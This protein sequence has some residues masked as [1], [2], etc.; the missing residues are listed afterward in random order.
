MEP[1]LDSSRH[2]RCARKSRVL[3]VVF[4]LLMLAAL[5]TAGSATAQEC[6]DCHDVK[7]TPHSA[8]ENMKCADCHK[9]R[10]EIPHPANASL[11]RCDSC[12]EEQAGQFRIGMH[13]R[14]RAAGNAAAPD[15]AVC[16]GSAHDVE[17]PGTTPFRRKTVDLCGSCHTKEATQYKRS[18]HGVAL[19]HGNR[20]VPYCVTCHGEHDNE[21]PSN[22]GA[23]GTIRETCARCHGNVA[24]MSRFGMPTDRIVSYDQ[25]YHG[26][27]LQAGSQRVANCASC[28][29]IH[30]ILPSSDPRSSTNVKNL[31]HTCGKCHPGAGTR[32]AIGPIHVIEGHGQAPIAD[33]IRKI[34]LVLIPL[35]LILMFVHNLGD[36][37]RKLIARAR[38]AAR[39]PRPTELRMLPLERVQ[40]AMLAVT[41][42]I[43]GWSGF[44][45]KFPDEFW[46]W[47]LVAPGA[48]F[49]GDIHRV[50]AVLFIMTS[51][52]HLV[53]LIANK[54]LRGRWIELLPRL[55]DVTEAWRSFLYNIGLSRRKPP[56]SDH[57][58]IEK[59]EYWAVVWG[60]VIMSAT[61]IWLWATDFFLTWFPKAMMDVATVIHY[62]EAILAVAAIVIWH[63]YS[64]IF[65]PDVYPMSMA[66]LTGQGPGRADSGDA[67][68]DEPDAVKIAPGKGAAPKD[69]YY[70]YDPDK[71]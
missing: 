33:L 32:F 65:D 40:H 43:L 16:H 35:T 12:H 8:H 15:C 64:V 22:P 11:P 60:A 68:E 7:I 25:S 67:P 9:D 71:H 27:A 46:A 30:D 18:V 20:D 36:F 42:I 34:Y 49:R 10:V 31:P 14:A 53:L 28:H 63:F 51:V 55:R 59:A 45:L 56:V 52:L 69:V 5:L 54:R 1:T 44:A 19:S 4:V 41:F 21:L 6:T 38:G 66:W 23:G 47:P 50:C 70:P 3:H 24:L 2:P 58:Y 48:T 62:Y 17:R 37:L 13:G 61:G 57:S 26:L 29:G 39:R